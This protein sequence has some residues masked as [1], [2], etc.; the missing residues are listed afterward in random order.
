MVTVSSIRHPQRG[1]F[2]NC[3][4]NVKFNGMLDLAPVIGNNLAALRKAR[5]ITQG[6]LSERFNYSDKAVSKWERGESLPDINVLQELAD[7]YGVTLDYLTHPQDE[8]S[9]KAVGSSNP[10]RDRVNKIILTALTFLVIATVATVIAMICYIMK[11]NW[12]WWLPFI[13]AVPVMG[14]FFLILNRRWGRYAFKLPG[15]IFTVWTLLA[16]TYIEVGMDLPN[17]NGWSFWYIFFAGIP[18]TLIY[19]IYSKIRLNKIK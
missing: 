7:F 15:R 11:S 9:L 13:W 18:I 4:K 2:F 17:G 10:A 5:G 16:A 3:P 19:V 12:T 14:I 1:A 6:E 8:D